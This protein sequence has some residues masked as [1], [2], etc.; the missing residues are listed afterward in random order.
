MN[1]FEP[2]ATKLGFIGL[3]NMGSR[4]AA[5][6]LAAGYSVSVYDRNKTKG[7]AL[8]GKGASLP[9]SL[10]LSPNPLTSSSL[11]LPTINPFAMHISAPPASWPMPKPAW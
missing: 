6:L 2:T 11:A 3:G 5:R 9:D 8:K 7:E 4:I 1:S 10:R